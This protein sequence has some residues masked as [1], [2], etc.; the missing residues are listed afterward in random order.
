MTKDNPMTDAERIFALESENRRLTEALAAAQEEA[1]IALAE[2]ARAAEET[3]IATTA[4][5]EQHLIATRR[6]TAIEA[7][8]KARDGE[9]TNAI[10]RDALAEAAA[11][12]NA[13]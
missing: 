6:E 7:A 11:P 4:A 8:L 3:R 2:L 5:G 10:L 13:G 1:R 12:A 9:P